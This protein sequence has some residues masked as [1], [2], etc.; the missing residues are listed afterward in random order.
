M[1]G[2]QMRIPT[3]FVARC[4]FCGEQLDIREDDVTYCVAGWVPQG[5]VDDFELSDLVQPQPTNRWA[6]LS[7]VE[8]AILGRGRR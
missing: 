8:R 3:I 4:K 5:R 6:H 2:D 7:C 1:T